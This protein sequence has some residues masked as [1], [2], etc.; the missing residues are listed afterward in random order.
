MKKLE[1]K[2]RNILNLNVWLV[3]PFIDLALF[4]NF[5]PA[6]RAPYRVSCFA[7]TSQKKYATLGAHSVCYNLKFD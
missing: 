3:L 5:D 7:H 4:S 1:M 6:H 2:A